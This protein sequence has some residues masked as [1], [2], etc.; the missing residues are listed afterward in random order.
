MTRI[1]LMSESFGLLMLGALS[2]EKMA[3]CWASPEQLFSGPKEFLGTH[4]HI[5]LSKIQDSSNP[6][7]Q[8]PVFIFPRNKVT[9]IYLQALGSRFITS[10]DSRG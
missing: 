9:L 3:L 10:Y 7:G 5:L 1:L 2:D 4:D 8:V 6:E